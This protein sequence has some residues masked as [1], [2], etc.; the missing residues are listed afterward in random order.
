MEKI[1]N[2]DDLIKSNLTL[3]TLN[4]CYLSVI[5]K[6]PNLHNN[7]Y[8]LN[9][10]H[11][12]LKGEPV[13]NEVLWT[14]TLKLSFNWFYKFRKITNIAFLSELRTEKL[15]ILEKKNLSIAWY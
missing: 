8:K 5:A 3:V 12:K 14:N 9:I 4:D 6:Y 1:D 13:S 2:F 7:D 15:H 11:N 10:L